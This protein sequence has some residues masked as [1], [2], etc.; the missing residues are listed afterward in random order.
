MEEIK[1][2]NILD[3]IRNSKKNSKQ[4]LFEISQALIK[5]HKLLGQIKEGLSAGSKVEKGILMES[6]EYASKDDPSIAEN[7]ID[8]VVDYLDYEDSPRVKWEGARVIANISQRYPEKAVRAVD[9]LL[10]N[11]KDQ[12]T[13]VR[14]SAAF[15]LGEIAKYNLKARAGL[16]PKI[17]AVLKKEQNSG[18]KNVY[19]KAL[20]TINK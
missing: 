8:T 16:L 7:M 1:T 17:E 13:V 10:E 14:W 2:M 11:A 5:D 20:K 9:K 15:A 4:L 18:V 3:E 12:G 19:L 6:L